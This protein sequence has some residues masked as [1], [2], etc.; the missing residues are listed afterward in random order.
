[1]YQVKTGE[2]F[3]SSFF[4]ELKDE[5]DLDKEVV[6]I[7]IKLF[8]EKKFTKTNIYNELENFRRQLR[9]DNEDK[10]D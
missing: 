10:V 3:A 1:M 7:L 8:E 2:E 5:K 6:N 4:K 9:S